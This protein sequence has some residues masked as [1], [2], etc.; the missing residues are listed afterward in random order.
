MIIAA[1]RSLA[2]R[3]L[4][5]QSVADALGVHRKSLHYYVKDREGMLEMV[6]ADVF[7]SEFRR[8]DLPWEGDW[9][10]L[11]RAAGRAMRAALIEVG[12]LLTY[13]DFRGFAGQESLGVSERILEA[14]VAAG[15]DLEQAGLAFALLSDLAY[16][17]AREA[18]IAANEALQLERAQQGAP[19][20]PDLRD[21]IAGAGAEDLPLLRQLIDVRSPAGYRD[22]QFEF[23]LSMLIIGLEKLLASNSD[24]VRDLEGID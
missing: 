5:M 16:C 17:G 1:A 20:E 6:A 22:K 21:E 14:L 18:M 15:L 9:R 4:T 23:S 11:F 7:E 2:S 8:A 3:E 24:P 19:V 10:N 13:A 12:A